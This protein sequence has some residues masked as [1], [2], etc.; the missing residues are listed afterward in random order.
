MVRL[1]TSSSR[2]SEALPSLIMN[3]STQGR[4]KSPRCAWMGIRFRKGPIRLSE[5]WAKILLLSPKRILAF[6]LLRRCS[7]CSS[8]SMEEDWT[9]WLKHE[10]IAKE[11]KAKAYK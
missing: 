2:K 7:Q 6:G 11:L 4:G 1:G 8:T 10:S 5:R 9:V 3:A